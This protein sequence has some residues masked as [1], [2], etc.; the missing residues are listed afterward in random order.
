M[1]PDEPP[2]PPGPDP[3][4]ER[5][6][7]TPDPGPD[8]GPERSDGSQ[9]PGLERSDGSQ[10]PGP[11]RPDGSQDPGSQDPGP[12]RSD[13]SQ[14]PGPERPDGS[15]GPGPEGPAGKVLSA[16]EHADYERYRR[17]GAV[18][19]RRA[20][21]GVASVLLLVTLLLSIPAVIAAWTADTVSDT[22]RYVAT[23]APLASEPAVQAVVTDRLTERVVANVDVDAVTK[24]LGKALA[25]AGAPPAVVDR[26]EALN[27]PLKAA[28]TNVVRDIV[29]RVVT[30]DVFR[31]TWVDANRRAHSAV[32]GMLTGDRSGAVR[33]EGD[34]IKLDVGT[35]ID[36]V[37]QRLVDRG[38][39]KA[40]AIP[41]PD[42]Q[43]TLFRTDKLSEAQDALRLLDV[44]G[45][46]LPVLTL[47]CA[48]LAVWTAPAHR[49]MLLVTAAG[50]AVAMIVLLVGLAVVRRV[51]LDSVPASVLPTDAAA[52]IY[53]TFVRFL[54]DSTRTLLVVALI[55]ALAAYLYGPGRVARWVRRQAA[56]GTGAAGRALGDAGL[57]TGTA[58]R[59]LDTHGSWTTGIVIGGGSLALLLW[60]RP[61]V[62]VVVLVVCLV[63]LVLAV[64]AVLAA[65]VPP[66][67]APD[68]GAA[69]GGGDFT[70]PG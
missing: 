37:K 10:D 18:R 21:Y 11:E 20:R 7:G 46:W 63:L 14:D 9:G 68:G 60:N 34:S 6:D 24:A 64:L 39:D 58:G 29:H 4:P 36:T 16:E 48:A 53:D 25:D 49:M 65:A 31:E 69:A 61:T 41:A 54:R 38:F 59:W 70:R 19:H 28:V 66:R 57:R 5:P 51:Y 27:G 12:E 2:L 17:A 33:A 15:Q 62:G 30:S 45:A 44:M 8:P 35:V 56:R 3:G 67:T 55:T 47:A 40:S 52:V 13:G 1:A 42:Q 32:V 26:T 50:V 23:V 43:I 22:D